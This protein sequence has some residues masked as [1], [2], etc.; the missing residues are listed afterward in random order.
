[1]RLNK[2]AKDFNVG[3][4]TLVEFLEK[5]T[6][7]TVEEGKP[8]AMTN[9]TDEQYELL[10]KE[11]NKDKSVKEESE[12]ERQ[13]RQQT[14][15]KIKE[16]TRAAAVQTPE[17]AHTPGEEELARFE[18][19]DGVVSLQHDRMKFDWTTSTDK[20]TRGRITKA[21][22]TY[23]DSRNGSSTL[24]WN[25]DAFKVMGS[26]NFPPKHHVEVKA[27]ADGKVKVTELDLRL[28]KLSNDSDWEP[29][30]K[31]SSKYERMDAESV[32]RKIFGGE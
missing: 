26:K 20:A 10:R 15:D 3:I 27:Q 14:R 22:A 8:L 17:K 21:C 29:R 18:V 24:T 4:Q 16:E 19:A 23:T 11:F 5:K 31:V 9:V 32:L 6:G 7:F 28:D 30:T 25:Y 13:E 12:R 2:I 1:M